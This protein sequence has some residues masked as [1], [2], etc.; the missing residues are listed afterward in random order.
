[1]KTTVL[2][3]PRWL[4][5]LEVRTSADGILL[6]PLR[7]ARAHWT[8]SFRRPPPTRDHPAATRQMINDFDAKEWEW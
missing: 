1:M 4:Y 7:K 3:L 2:T 8:K 6:C 5:G